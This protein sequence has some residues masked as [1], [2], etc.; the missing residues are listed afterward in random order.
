MPTRWARS[1]PCGNACKSCPCDSTW[2]LPGS[3]SAHNRRSRLDLPAPLWPIR[4]DARLCQ[5]QAQAGEHLRCAP[6]QV[7]LAQLQQGSGGRGGIK[8]GQGHSAGLDEVVVRQILT[9]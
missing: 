7:H 6:A 3:S 2:P 1:R 4:T 8:G 9:T 5:R